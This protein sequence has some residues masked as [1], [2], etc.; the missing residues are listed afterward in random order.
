MSLSPE[1]LGILACPACKGALVYEEDA[2]RLVCNACRLRY[3][4]VGG[5]P[6]MLIDKAEKF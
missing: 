1:L 3:R 5:V 6:V 2:Q 4:V